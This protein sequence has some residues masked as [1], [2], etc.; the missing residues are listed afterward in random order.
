[1]TCTRRPLLGYAAAGAV[2]PVDTRNRRLFGTFEVEDDDDLALR[3]ALGVVVGE[4]QL[5]LVLTDRRT[6]EGDRCGPP[7]ED[8]LLGWYGC[9]PHVNGVL[10]DAQFYLVTAR[11]SSTRTAA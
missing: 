10:P 11:T 1:M 8:A 4:T 9:V 5:T 7:S 3:R 2:L 6:G